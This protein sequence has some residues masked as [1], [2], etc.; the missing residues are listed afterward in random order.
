MQTI[1]FLVL[2]FAGAGIFLYALV[3]IPVN[4]EKPPPPP[5]PVAV[6]G[7]IRPPDEKEKKLKEEIEKKLEE[8]RKRRE[9]ERA[10]EEEIRKKEE[11]ENRKERE[12]LR[13]EMEKIAEAV[14]KLAEETAKPPPPPPP[15]V[16]PEAIAR[17]IRDAMPLPKESPPPLTKEEIESMLRKEMER[18]KEEVKPPSPPPVPPPP[19][20]PPPKPVAPIADPAIKEAVVQATKK[21]TFYLHLHYDTITAI[22][23]LGLEFGV[24][25]PDGTVTHLVVL[26]AQNSVVRFEDYGREERGKFQETVF[27][28]K[29]VPGVRE[30]ESAVLA[31][32]PGY[33]VR[34]LVPRSVWHAKFAPLIHRARTFCA[35]YGLP[36]EGILIAIPEEEGDPYLDQI[37][38]QGNI[39]RD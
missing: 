39:Y 30:I 34:L 21:G 18:W 10:R 31:R 25:M 7:R 38:S 14:K 11:E 6:Q 3:K 4:F 12:Q 17:A 35:R 20:A 5:R 29:T 32:F 36:F 1:K 37:Y 15:Q 13:K 8:E 23:R 2:S 9:E 26:D 33:T 19:P 22:R 28:T 27:R 16:T 24:S